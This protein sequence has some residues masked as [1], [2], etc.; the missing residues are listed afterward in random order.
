VLP[1]YDNTLTR[2]WLLSFLLD[3]GV[4]RTDGDL[5]FSIEDA[6]GG[7]KRIAAHF[8]FCVPREVQASDARFLFKPGESIRLFFS[9]R[10]RPERLTRL[11]GQYGLCVLDH[12][13]TAT[14]EEGVFLIR[15]E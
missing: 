13:L 1:L 2:E 15:K 8:H 9:Y 14:G 6:E 4:E 5:V 11:L 7:L 10:H 12:W 3:L